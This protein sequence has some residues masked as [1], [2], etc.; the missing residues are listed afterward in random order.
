MYFATH[1]FVGGFVSSGLFCIAKNYPARNTTLMIKM[2]KFHFILAIN[3]QQVRWLLAETDKRCIFSSFKSVWARFY[4]T[5]DCS[6]IPTEIPFS[7]RRKS[8][9]RIVSWSE[10][11]YCA[12]TLGDVQ[13]RRGV[14]YNLIGNFWWG[15]GGGRWQLINTMATSHP[16]P[17]TPHLGNSNI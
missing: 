8:A 3:S 16:L 6:Q 1:T 4:C 10:I 5:S 12:S 2:I 15:V 14:T 7:S 11:G 17:P 9:S 13:L